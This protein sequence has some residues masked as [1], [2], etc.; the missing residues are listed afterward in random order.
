M[1]ESLWVFVAVRDGK[2]TICDV[3]IGDF[4]MPLVTSDPALLNDMDEN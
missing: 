1:I 3:K 4:W 2:E